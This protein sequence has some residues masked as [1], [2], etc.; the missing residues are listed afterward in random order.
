ME[1][2]DFISGIFSYTGVLFVARPAFLFPVDATTKAASPLAVLCALGGALT[3][4]CAYVC[5]R[6]LHDLSFM[7]IIHYFL[8]FGI[9][10]SL[11]TLLTFNT[12]RT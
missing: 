12:M 4:A 2:I 11:M 5:M 6:K 9:C 8:L 10:F 7:V 1:R 3:Q